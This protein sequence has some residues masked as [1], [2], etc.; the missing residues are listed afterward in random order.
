MKARGALIFADGPASGHGGSAVG[1]GGRARFG[2]RDLL[3]RLVA[4]VR[5]LAGCTVVVPCEEPFA[6][7]YQAAH[8]EG[9]AMTPPRSA[10]DGA[11]EALLAALPSFPPDVT[12]I[13]VATSD[14]PY[15]DSAWI[16]RM[17]EA[18]APGADAVCVVEEGRRRPLLAVYRAQALRDAEAAGPDAPAPW[19][20]PRVE[21]LPAGPVHNGSATVATR[22][23]SPEAYRRALAH[24]GFCDGAHPAVTL[25]L[26]GNLRIRTGCGELPIHG[27]SVRTVCRVLQRVYPESCKWLPEPE[28][29]AEHFRFSINGGEVVAELDHPLRENDH[30]ILFSATVGG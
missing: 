2:D 4:E 15:L 6:P 5:P 25:E 12:E 9:V 17:F 3:A 28:Q 21:E 29:L 22:V 7:E 16:E 19:E 18:L 27:D 26:Y 20:G 30:L 8:L 10:A 23:D 11:R 1:L 24:L 14:L 13:A